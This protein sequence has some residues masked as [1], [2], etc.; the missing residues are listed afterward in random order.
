MSGASR[1]ASPRGTLTA[2]STRRAPSPSPPR[3]ARSSSPSGSGVCP[4]GSQIR[5][6]CGRTRTPANQWWSSGW[7]TSTGVR[8]VGRSTPA[9]L[10]RHPTRELTRVDFPAPVDPP[11]TA[12][13]GA[14]GSLRRGRR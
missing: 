13:S 2:V 14:S 7:Q 4:G 9:S 6:S 3:A 11:I 8:V 10:T 1:S 12:S 5:V